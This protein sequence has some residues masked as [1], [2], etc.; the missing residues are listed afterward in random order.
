MRQVWR[1]LGGA[2]YSSRRVDDDGVAERRLNGLT[3]SDGSPDLDD[4][5]TLGCLL[6][7]VREAWSEPAVHIAW[8]G[9]AECWRVWITLDGGKGGSRVFTRPTEAEALVA[10]LESAP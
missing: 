3:L 9:I 6:A 8:R 10:A 2:I 1:Q 7:L 5:A 4:P